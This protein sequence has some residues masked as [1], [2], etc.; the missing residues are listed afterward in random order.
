MMVWLHH[1][2]Y[3]LVIFTL[4]TQAAVGAFWVL[5][6]NDFLKR[7]DPGAVQD[8][9]T[10]IGS[11]ILL[12]LTAIG[13]VMSVTHLGQPH[14]AFR[15]LLN[16]ES[17]WLSREVWSLSFFFGLAT[18]YAFLWWRHVKDAE[19]RRLAGVFTALVGGAGILSQAMVYQIPGRPMWN[20]PSVFVQFFASALLL[21]PLT[22]ATVYGF[23]W[24]RVI[25]REAGE[26]TVRSSHRRL[27]ITLVLAAGLSAIGIGWRGAF[28]SQGWAQARANPQVAGWAAWGEATRSTALHVGASAVK[29]A[30]PFLIL[31]IVLGLG[32]PLALA[33]GLRELHRRNASL[34]HCNRWI[35]AALLLTL[36]GEIF[37]RALFYLSGKPWF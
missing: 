4:F 13:M 5:L 8:G 16:V 14:V 37:G 27:G 35:F 15:A 10:R 20:H 31:Q 32:V 33:V 29:E 19:L 6:V 11:F 21:G 34:R 26:E 22:V 36:T 2:Q 12:P 1:V 17:S 18:I 25:S 7:R 30:F 3:G 9:F 23:T 24:G 28:L